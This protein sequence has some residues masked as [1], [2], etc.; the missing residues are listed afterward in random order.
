MK[1][2]KLPSTMMI[3]NINGELKYINRVGLVLTIAHN[4]RTYKVEL[5]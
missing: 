1:I 2:I 4:S 3:A 5:I